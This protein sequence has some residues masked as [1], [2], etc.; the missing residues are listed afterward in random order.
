MQMYSES[1]RPQTTSG[2]AGWI[3]DMHSADRIDEP[4][5]TAVFNTLTRR[6]A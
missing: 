1:T 5:I 2:F 4:V 6:A 3:Q